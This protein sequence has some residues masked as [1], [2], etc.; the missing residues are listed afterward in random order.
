[1]YTLPQWKGYR[2]RTEV[3]D[4]DVSEDTGAN[5]HRLVRVPLAE[6]DEWD[7]THDETGRLRRR[8]VASGNA[9]GSDD[10]LQGDEKH[11]AQNPSYV[12][13]GPHAPKS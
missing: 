2:I 7:Q 8:H 1:M 10:S 3:L 5:T 6:L 12:Q 11:A 13:D 9:A 4:V